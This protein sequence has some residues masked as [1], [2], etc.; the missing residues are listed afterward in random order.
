MTQLLLSL[1]AGLI[2]AALVLP[3]LDLSDNLKSGIG[4]AIVIATAMIGPLLPKASAAARTAL[5]L[6]RRG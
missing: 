2:A 5:G 1:N 4:A 3:Q 6:Q